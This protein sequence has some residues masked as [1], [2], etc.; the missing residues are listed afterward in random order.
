MASFKSNRAAGEACWKPMGSLYCWGHAHHPNCSTLPSASALQQKS[1][2]ESDLHSCLKKYTTSY[3]GP[4]SSRSVKYSLIKYS[5]AKNT[6]EIMIQT[7]LLLS[8]CLWVFVVFDQFLVPFS[9]VLK[10]FRVHMNYPERLKSRKQTGLLWVIPTSWS[11]SI[12]LRSYPH[13]DFKQRM[14]WQDNTKLQ[15]PR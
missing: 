3:L 15:S 11:I 4:L 10:F 6:A 1:K 9:R 5:L 12:K 2:E 8:T 7:K 13:T 14:Y